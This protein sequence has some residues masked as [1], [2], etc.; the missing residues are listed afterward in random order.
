MMD[1]L[2]AQR[3]AYIQPEQEKQDRFMDSAIDM[4]T[5]SIPFPDAESSR[6]SQG[7]RIIFQSQQSQ[8]QQQ[9]MQIQA[10]NRQA[11]CE[12]WDLENRLDQWV[13]KCPLC[14]VRKCTGSPVDF[15]HTLNECADLEQELVRTEV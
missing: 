13:G 9:R 5:S 2:E 6:I 7:E 14:Y 3:R 1:D 15:R 4:P 10:R 11:G 12:V 8:Q